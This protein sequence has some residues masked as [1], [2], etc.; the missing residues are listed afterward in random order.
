MDEDTQG[1]WKGQPEKIE[2]KKLKIVGNLLSKMIADPRKVPLG[3][4]PLCGPRLE[5]RL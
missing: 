2:L 1:S 5:P 4:N 3:Q